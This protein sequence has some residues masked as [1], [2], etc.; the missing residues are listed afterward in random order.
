MVP[1]KAW[2]WGWCVSCY[3]EFIL[4]SKWILSICPLLF[5]IQLSCGGMLGWSIVNYRI[6]TPLAWCNIWWPEDIIHSGHLLWSANSMGPFFATFHGM[7]ALNCIFESVKPKTL[8]QR[9][10]L[11]RSLNQSNRTQTENYFRLSNL[12]L[13]MWSLWWIKHLGLIVLTMNNR[14]SFWNKLRC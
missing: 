2:V 3:V 5:P 14:T 4:C 6:V 1:S 10:N 7:F 11:N 9:P 12:Q 8:D 13:R